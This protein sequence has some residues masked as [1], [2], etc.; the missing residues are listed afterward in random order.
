MW[1]VSG[2]ASLVRLFRKRG[3]RR[4]GP[5]ITGLESYSGRGKRLWILGIAV[6]ETVSSSENAERPEAGPPPAPELVPRHG[7]QVVE[8][9]PDRLSEQP[10]GRI[11]V[12]MGA[13]RRLRNDAVDHAEPQAM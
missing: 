12:G 11:R 1:F 5:V 2:Q 9:L 3:V 6:R 13:S 10:G 4:S 8:R 7:L